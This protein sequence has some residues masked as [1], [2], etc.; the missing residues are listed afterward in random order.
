MNV[1]VLPYPVI[2]K[3]GLGKAS[4]KSVRVSKV[5]EENRWEGGWGGEGR[6]CKHCYKV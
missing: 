1:I 2:I 5:I 3:A 4:F 6:N